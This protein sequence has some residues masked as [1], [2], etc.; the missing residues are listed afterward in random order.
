MLKMDAASRLVIC[1]TFIEPI[2]L[3]FNDTIDLSLSVF[4]V[5]VS[6]TQVRIG[7]KRHLWN[8]N[9]KNE[10]FV[11]FSLKLECEKLAQEKTEMQRHYVMVSQLF[12]FVGIWSEMLS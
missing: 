12:F 6:K 11:F 9:L 1:E 10:C 3:L 2:P 8:V 7:Y 5:Q 4:Y